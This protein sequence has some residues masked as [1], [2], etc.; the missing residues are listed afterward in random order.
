VLGR[1]VYLGAEVLV[2]WLPGQTEP[3]DHW[4]GGKL[5]PRRCPWRPETPAPQMTPE[6]RAALA[7]LEKSISVASTNK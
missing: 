6:R 7:A 3:C 1:Y 2:A 5:N 4:F